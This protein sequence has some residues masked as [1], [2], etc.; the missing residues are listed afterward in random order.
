VT[1]FATWNVNS[2]KVR[3]E[4]VEQ[5]LADIEPD[6]VCM[7]ETKLADSAFP[8]L[9]FESLGYSAVH[10]GEG[11]WNGVALLSREGLVD[12][13]FGFADDAEPDHEARL[14]TATCDGIRIVNIYVPNGRSLDSDHYVYKLS[15]LERLNA[16]LRTVAAPGDDVIIA[17]DFNIAPA[18]ADVYDPAV[19][20]GTTHTSGPER[21]QLDA[22]LDFGLIDMFRQHHPDAQRVFSWWDYR[23]GDFHEG[24]GMRIDLVLASASVAARAEWMIID[25]NARKGKLPSDHAPLVLDLADR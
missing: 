10:H 18:D 15:W 23:A 13:T 21:D 2:L 1:R 22:L 16:H 20:V 17:G 3:Q 25:R 12:V 4:R 8:Q 11:R 5:W 24:R 19:Y 9:A 6:I 14:M 7:Q